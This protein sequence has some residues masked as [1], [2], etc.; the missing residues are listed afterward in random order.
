MLKPLDSRDV[1]AFL[2]RAAAAGASRGRGRGH[3]GRRHHR[4]DA[5]PSGAR[6]ARSRSCYTKNVRDLIRQQQETD[7]GFE[8]WVR[9]LDRRPRGAHPR[10]DDDALHWPNSASVPRRRKS[11]PVSRSFSSASKAP[12]LRIERERAAAKA[13]EKAAA[14][15][16]PG[17]GQSAGQAPVRKGLSPEAVAAIREVVPRAARARRASAPVDPWNP[18]LSQTGGGKCVETCQLLVREALV[19]ARVPRI[20][21]APR[22]RAARCARRP[23]LRPGAHVV[24]DLEV[25]RLSSGSRCAP[26]GCAPRLRN[27]A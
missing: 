20:G 7:R 10:A 11:S 1:R 8:M 27:R 12:K 4:R 24:R 16:A 5:V 6:A 15:T 21:Y 14:K 2:D 3:R 17:A 22:A 25:V 18:R 19:T 13:A 23:G 26:I 9:A